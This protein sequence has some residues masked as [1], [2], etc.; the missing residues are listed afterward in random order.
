EGNDARYS[1]RPPRWQN[2]N[3]ITRT[4][5]PGSQGSR[6][7][8]E[9]LIRAYNALHR[10]TEWMIAPSDLHRYLFQVLEQTWAG[11]P[12]H[13]V[14]SP[15]HVVAFQGANGQEECFDRTEGPQE[16]AEVILDC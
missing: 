14:T 10:E 1:R 13:V 15:H 12:R 11:K 2:H 3:R 4:N 9:V 6:V 16:F 7:A 8:S 5:L